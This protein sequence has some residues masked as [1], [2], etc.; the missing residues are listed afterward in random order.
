MHLCESSWAWDTEYTDECMTFFYWLST[1]TEEKLYVI[2]Y[3]LNV[4]VNT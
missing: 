2:L 4:T 1:T 3:K